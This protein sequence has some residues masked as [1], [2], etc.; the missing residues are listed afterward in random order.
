MFL[1]TTDTYFLCILNVT[2]LHDSVWAYK[3][4]LSRRGLEE[5]VVASHFSETAAKKETSI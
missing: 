5:A 2:Y 3:A 1:Q 4:E